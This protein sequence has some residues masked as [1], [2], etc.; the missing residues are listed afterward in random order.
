MGPSMHE[1]SMKNDH[2]IQILKPCMLVKLWLGTLGKPS[3]EFTR[4]Q[5]SRW[6]GDSSNT[7]TALEGSER[8]RCPMV[9][10]LIVQLQIRIVS[11][12]KATGYNNITTG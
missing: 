8:V 1:A 5:N 7:T 12:K 4:K 2:V 11:W 9:V 3:E 10:D 6:N